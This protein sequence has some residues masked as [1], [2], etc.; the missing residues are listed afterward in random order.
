MEEGIVGEESP[1]SPAAAEAGESAEA[2]AA[3]AKTADA[4][5]AAAT[6][7]AKEAAAVVGRLLVE[8]GNFEKSVERLKSCACLLRGEMAVLRAVKRLAEDSV[9]VLALDFSEVAM[10]MQKEVLCEYADRRKA[11]E[12]WRRFAPFATKFFLKAIVPMYRAQK[13][14]FK[15]KQQRHFKEVTL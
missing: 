14:A 2:R 7:A 5:A 9:V 15:V 3:D 6:A 1:L 10:A 13:R 11:G 8:A 12:G 4:A